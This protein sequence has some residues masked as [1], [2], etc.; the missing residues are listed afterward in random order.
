MFP[1]KL[2]HTGML[3][4]CRGEVESRCVQGAMCVFAVSHPEEESNHFLHLLS[5]FYLLVPAGRGVLLEQWTDVVEIHC[6][7][8]LASEQ[9]GIW[10]F[11]VMQRTSYLG[12]ERSPRF[13]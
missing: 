13:S 3:Q 1:S 11:A 4:M 8:C 5:W 7:G 9:V 6:R 12:T 2:E 10:F